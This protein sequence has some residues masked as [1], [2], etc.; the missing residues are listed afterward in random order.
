MCLCLVGKKS[1]LST[2]VYL[3]TKLCKSLYEYADPNVSAADPNKA[4]ADS[5]KITADPDTAADPE[6]QIW[7][8]IHIL[9]KIRILYVFYLLRDVKLVKTA[10]MNLYTY[11]I[12][13]I[14]R[15]YFYITSYGTIK[16]RY[17]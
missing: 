12:F 15:T 3:P 16:F 6:R 14:I 7:L 17:G 8:R 5:N 11:S 10:V 9:S 1:M 4:A 13:S 2:M